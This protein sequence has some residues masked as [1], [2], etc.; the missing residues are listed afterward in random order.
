MR[1][2]YNAAR[3]QV[4]TGYD[5]AYVLVA[6]KGSAGPL[7]VPIGN[8]IGNGDYKA[9]N[10]LEVSNVTKYPVFVTVNLYSDNLSKPKKVTATLSPYSQ[11][12]IPAAT[13]LDGADNGLAVIES[14]EPQSVVA[15]S[16]YYF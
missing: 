2:G 13:L 8:S 6:T 5:F 7:S 12:H 15:N 3:G 11:T 1:Y 9:D 4:N 10:W 14:S 16:M